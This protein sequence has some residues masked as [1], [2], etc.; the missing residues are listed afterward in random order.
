MALLP[1]RIVDTIDK[2]K[3]IGV[4]AGTG[5]HKVIGIWAVVVDGRVFARSWGLTPGG[6]H[7]TFIEERRGYLEVDGKALPVRAV[8]TKSERLKDAVTRA[9][10]EKYNTKASMKWVKGMSRGRRR[11]STTEFVPLSTT[12]RT[13]NAKLTKNTRRK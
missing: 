11:D 9:Y 8:R 12:K 3:I 2:A 4:R 6:W 1:K 5:D 10:E 7:R 13:K